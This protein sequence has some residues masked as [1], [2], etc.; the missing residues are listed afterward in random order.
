M[1]ASATMTRMAGSAGLLDEAQSET[2]SS[3][4]ST[5]TPEQALW[6][7]GYLAGLAGSPPASSNGGEHSGEA[8][9]RVTVLYGTETGNAES[10]ACQFVERAVE[11]GLQ[12][13]AVDMADY[14][15]KDLRDEGWLVL[16]SATHGEGDPPEPAAGFFEYLWSRK[17]PDLEGA[18]F[19]VLAL[20]DSSYAY[21][22]KAGRDLDERFEELGAQRIAD[23]EECDVDFEEA[24]GAWVDALVARLK[25]EVPVAAP[26]GVGT[27]NG[28]GTAPKIPDAV[29][30]LLQGVGGRASAS[31]LGG[32]ALAT[33]PAKPKYTRRHPYRAEVLENLRL[34]GR[35]SDKETHHVELLVE[36]GELHFEPG[37]SLGI[38]PE[39]EEPLVEAVVEALGLSGGEAVTVGGKEW[40][41]AEAL[42]RELEL[43]RL[44]PAFLRSYAEVAQAR[45]L[46]ALL[47]SED[48][49]ALNWYMTCNQVIDVLESYPVEGLQA[50]VFVEM[51]RKLQPRLYSIA[52]SAKWM[53]DQ[54]D[55]TVAITRTTADGK[56]RNGV[57][58]SYL[59]ERR[60]PGDPLD[61]YVQ[62]NKSFRM[63]TDPDA[64]ILMIGPGTGVAP[65]RAFLQEREEHGASGPTWLFF[66][67]R[68][69]R[70]DFLYQTEWQRFLETGVLTRM[71]VAFSRDQAEKVYVQ[72]R[73]RDRAADVF[74]WLEDGAYLYVCGDA[75]AM[76]PDVHRTL[77]DVVREEGSRSNEEAEAYLK[78]LQEERR[79]QRDVY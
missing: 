33:A 58:S 9:P 61:V 47:S 78:E 68:R 11:E 28:N 79:Y 24:S 39:N 62:R 35:G 51:L 48:L 59:A 77:V 16:I 5:L 70:E 50:Q 52:S 67:E 65:F 43:T 17:A 15:T 42:R 22:C 69:F 37:D 12:A 19:A 14:R 30:G 46:K 1:E 56:A 13:R 71:D 21:Y 25:K 10:V 4:I 27:G 63:P 66:G 34:N 45:E 31:V 53:P 38:V 20:G 41:L 60:S 54:I 23:R 75:Q 2:A 64:P 74:E 8:G 6:L 32:G 44:T 72:D 18:R 40:A 57:A 76:A 29:G 7:S 55:L 49:E 73:L 36:E 26:A 3:L